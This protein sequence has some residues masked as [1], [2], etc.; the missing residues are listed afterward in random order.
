MSDLE[1]VIGLE[2]HVQLN[3]NTKMFCGCENRDELGAPNVAICPI[4]TGQPGTLPFPNKAAIQKG[5]LAGLALQAE[6]PDMCK[7]DRK[8][9]FYPDLPKGY[10]IS[11]F[12]EPL[13]KDGSVEIL[14]DEGNP[15]IIRIERAHLEEDAAK[16]TH[17]ASGTLVDY[18]RAGAPLLEIVTRPDFKSAKEAKQFLQELRL[19]MRTVN[20]SNADMEKGQMRCDVNISMR[21]TGSTEFFPKTEI[22]NVNSFKSVERAIMFEI[23]RQTALW[24]TNTPPSVTTTRGWDDMVQQTVLQRTKEAVHDYRYFPEPDIPPL[25]VADLILEGKRTLP[26]L[27]NA[28]KARLTKE[29][30]IKPTD[31]T[32]FA[33]NRDLGNFVEQ[34]MSELHEQLPTVI[35]GTL[36]DILEKEGEK[37]GKQVSG[38][39]TSKLQGILQERKLTIGETKLDAENFAELMMLI[40]TRRVNSTTAQSLLEK[41]VDTGVDP[42]IA[43]EDMG[44]STESVSTDAL[45]TIVQTVI[46]ENPDAV[47]KFKAGKTNLI[48]F[49]VGMCMKKLKGSGD[50]T[51]IK[52][53]LVEKIG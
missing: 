6:I 49:L 41:M 44:V 27:P 45:S 14:D 9:Y 7:F 12:D 33:E 32:F 8:H 1:V 18:N 30:S 21:P 51:E 31:A 25:F 36:E 47:Q 4:C 37:L 42:S 52:A 17:A 38:W 3:T 28:Y 39:I 20:V 13:V 22:K 15:R 29:F 40:F 11:Q 23:K 48:E 10:Q 50:P 53:K 46:D 5:I 2:I 35:D 19:L 26:E 34:V 24:E 16:N 43:L